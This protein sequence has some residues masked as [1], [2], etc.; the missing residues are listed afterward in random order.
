LLIL[1][2]RYRERVLGEDID[3]YNTVRPHQSL[4]LATPLPRGRPPTPTGEILRRDRIGGL[5]H[6]YERQAA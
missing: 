1:G 3:H 6:Q 5:I 2:R 4:G